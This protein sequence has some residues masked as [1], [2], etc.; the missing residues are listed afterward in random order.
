MVILFLLLSAGEVNQ[1]VPLWKKLSYSVGYSGG[2]CYRGEDLLSSPTTLYDLI[3]ILAC[4]VYLLH[5][6]ELSAIYPFGDGKGIEV[7]V[8]YGWAKVRKHEYVSYHF[9]LFSLYFGIRKNRHLFKVS[10]IL[11]KS[12]KEAVG[13]TIQYFRGKGMGVK[14][15]YVYHLHRFFSVELTGGSIGYRWYQEDLEYNI[16]LSLWGVGVCIGYTF[17]LPGGV[18]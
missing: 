9:D 7:G 5:S 12:I 2:I 17:N 6:I 1:D 16:K 18:R 11:S 8:G 10:G 13:D 14:V 4:Y 15:C 3:G